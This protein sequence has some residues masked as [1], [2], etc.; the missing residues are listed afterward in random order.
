MDCLMVEN[1]F[2][3]AGH[4][5]RRGGADYNSD[6]PRAVFLVTLIPP[7]PI[8]VREDCWRILPPL[9]SFVHCYGPLQS[10]FD[11]FWQLGR[12]AGGQHHPPPPLWIGCVW[13][14]HLLSPAARLY[15]FKQ[16]YH[17]HKLTA[18]SPNI[19]ALRAPL[20]PHFS[21]H[22][23]VSGIFKTGSGFEVLEILPMLSKHNWKVFKNKSYIR[24]YQLSAIFYFTL[25]Y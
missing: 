18:T 17:A 12:T 3:Y 7:L 6:P 8:L 20:N 9:P 24:I 10:S 15:Y 23:C 19:S 5:S 4:V 16:I 1:W 22:C 25:Q 21:V 13:L 2:S 11:R 14:P